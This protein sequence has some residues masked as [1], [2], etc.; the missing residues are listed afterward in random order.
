MTH[1]RFTSLLAVLILATGAAPALAQS[2]AT[3][4]GQ[5][6]PSRDTN[7]P[8][9]V[10]TATIAGA[11]T[12]GDADAK[13]VRRALVSLN[14]AELRG[15]RQ[16]ITDDAGRF[17]FSHLPAGRFTL[18]AA[19]PGYVTT[20]YGGTRPG[21]GP[22]IPLALTDGQTIGDLAL[23]MPWGAVIAGTV[24]DTNGQ[25]IT[26]LRV[27]VM[28]ARLV[29]GERTYSYVSGGIGN[30]TDDRGSYRLYGLPP[31]EF[32][33]AASSLNSIA[34]RLTTA[35]E[36]RWAQQQSPGPNRPV[37]AAAP[38]ASSGPPLGQPVTY[39]PVYYPGTPDASA[40][41]PVTV[42]SG[43]ER[44]GVDF[45]IPFVSTSKVE[46]VITRADGQSVQGTIIMLFSNSRVSSPFLES[47]LG[48]RAVVGADGKFVFRSV[49]PGQYT[50]TA[51][52]SSRPAGPPAPGARP[53]P[54]V[55]DLWALVD[56]TVSGGDVSGLAATLEPGMTVSGRIVFDGKVLTPP[57]DLSRVSVSL[58]VPPSATGVT[59][60]VP[61]GQANPDGTFTFH[62]VTPGRY[63]ITAT[64]GSLP[65]TAPGS[66]WQVKSA[67]LRGRELVDVPIE[68][69]PSEDLTD[70]VVTFTDQSSEVSGAMLDN[71]GRPVSEYYVFLF[72]TDKAQWFQGSR[73][74]RQPTRPASDGKYRLTGLPPGEYYVAALTDFEPTDIYDATFLEQLIAA[75]FKITLAEGEKKV[76]DLKLAGGK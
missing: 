10:G 67:T 41:A 13:P 16:A 42:R 6:P 65:G 51:R 19:K 26:S 58:R 22:G 43:E 71:T 47:P 57:E 39:A 54:P 46:G 66:G 53:A 30:P 18:Y 56:V 21:R 55:V 74:M 69:R 63:L 29:N 23:K 4:P 70:L 11:I 17:V 76:Q 1:P 32:V 25:P 20:Y 50:L 45:S 64:A 12:T 5:R 75:S 61:T 31:G 52:A 38:D 7:L 73:R 15:T 72:S 24:T 68:I 37:G 9:A 27:Q 14:G 8:P 36:I 49:R 44:T 2:I 59:L 40:S 48:N 3:A 33:V 34:A 60:G 62:G 35:D 28:E